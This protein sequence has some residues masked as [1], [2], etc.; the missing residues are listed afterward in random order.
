MKI[1]I[2][3]F[4]TIIVVFFFNLEAQNTVIYGDSIELSLK[5]YRNGHIQW[6]FSKDSIFWTDI[7]NYTLL[8]LNYS[9]KESGYY[10]ACIKTCDSTF[11]SSVKKIYS[12]KVIDSLYSKNSQPIFGL[13]DIRWCNVPV[14]LNYIQDQTHPSILYI[15]NKWNNSNIWL[16]TTPYPN[17]GFYE[18]PSIYFGDY[19]DSTLNCAF[20]P[21]QNNPINIITKRGDGYNA[22]PDL[23]LDDSILF[24]I[25]KQYLAS[26]KKQHYLIQSSLDGQNWTFPK[27]LFNSD[28]TGWEIV[29]PAIIKYRNKYRIYGAQTT[30]RIAGG[31]FFNLVILESNS[32]TD[33][34]F[35]IISRPIFAKK[36]SIEMWHFDLFERNNVLYMVFCGKNTAFS[37]TYLSTY[38][39]YSLDYTNFY[40]LPKPL[41]NDIYSYR[42]TAFIDENDRLSL[43]I[44]TMDSKHKIFSHD[45]NEIGWLSIP[46]S[47]L[48]NLLNN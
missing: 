38:L 34:K 47:K 15:P 2:F 10:R 18:N 21:I 13:N 44:S 14:P 32:L 35:K 20:T 28:F 7:K 25:Y 40:V 5:D 16:A 8:K 33:P 45:G 41:F 12:L 39:A 4:F 29:S 30:A 36:G 26:D 37:D 48:L 42:P 17:D 23:F 1:K 24:C 22:D 31:Q 11:F 27:E 19:S 3:F 43:I 9:V 46:F 6:Q